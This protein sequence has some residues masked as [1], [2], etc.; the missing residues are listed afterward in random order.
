ME[1]EED[2]GATPTPLPT[3]LPSCSPLPY[4]FDPSVPPQEWKKQK[5]QIKGVTLK[6]VINAIPNYT[7]YVPPAQEYVGL[8]T[9]T[10]HIQHLLD[11]LLFQGFQHLPWPGD[12][13]QLILDT[14]DACIMVLGGHLND[15]H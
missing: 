6:Q 12:E 7:V 5:K 8:C 2:L 14:M 10:N 11:D 9:L 1:R 4:V 13:P 3:K 15:P